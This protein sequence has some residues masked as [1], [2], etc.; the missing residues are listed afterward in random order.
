MVGEVS[1]VP[2]GQLTCCIT[3]DD[4]E[5][6]AEKPAQSHHVVVRSGVVGLLCPELRWL[7]LNVDQSCCC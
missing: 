6:E 5:C 3:V 4:V 2:A 7:L 1:L